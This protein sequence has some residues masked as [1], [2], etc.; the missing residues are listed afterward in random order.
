ME[1]GVYGEAK[2]WSLRAVDSKPPRETSSLILLGASYLGLGE[3][4]FAYEFFNKAFEMGKARAF[5]GFDKKYLNFLTAY[6]EKK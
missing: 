1:L 2:T 3:E 6:K 4:E 5:Q